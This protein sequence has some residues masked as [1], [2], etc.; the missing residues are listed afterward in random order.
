MSARIDPAAGTPVRHASGAVGTDPSVYYET[1]AP[2]AP[3][4]LPTVVMIHGGGHSGSCWTATADGRPGWAYDLVHR[5]HPVVVPDWPGIGRSGSIPVDEL[6]A[7]TVCKGL[8]GLI[9][10]IEGPVVLLTHSMGGALG[11]IVAEQNRARLHAVV[12]I[13]PGPPGNIQPEPTIL[14]STA[15]TITLATPHRTVTVP[16]SGHVPNAPAFIDQKLIGSGSQF[17]DAARAEYAAS[18]LALPSALLRQRLNIEGTQARVS[19]PGC[20]RDLP[21]LVLTGSHDLEHPYETDAAIVAWLQ[22]SGARAE[23]T[24]LPD[25]GIVGNGHML[26]L[27]RNS[28][29][30]AAMIC[31]WLASPSD[32]HARPTLLTSAET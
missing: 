3:T 12:A 21:I 22:Q 5:G 9:A 2:S 20:F 13:A 4:G 7:A 16:R 27:E 6:S 31:D 19:R 23:F 28:A 8:G 26:M 15:E 30:I 18:L 24:W 29:E 10:A 25:R 14:A 17:P 32:M 11:W 1:F